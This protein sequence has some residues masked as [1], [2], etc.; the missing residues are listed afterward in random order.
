MFKFFLKRGFLLGI[1]YIDLGRVLAIFGRFRSN[2]I[3]GIVLPTHEDS[4]SKIGSR[5]HIKCLLTSFL[6]FPGDLLCSY[7]T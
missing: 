4:E 1:S 7:Y 6:F 2:L 3:D 5:L